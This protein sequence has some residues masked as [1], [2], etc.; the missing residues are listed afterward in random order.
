[1]ECVRLCA[2]QARKESAPVP[3]LGS[4]A[5]VVS[6][7]FVANAVLLGGVRPPVVLISRYT[8]LI[9]IQPIHDSSD[10]L[11]PPWRRLKTDE[12]GPQPS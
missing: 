8:L 12:F 6:T 10:C 1:M 11:E 5:D 4:G 7:T 9:D 2:K 3:D